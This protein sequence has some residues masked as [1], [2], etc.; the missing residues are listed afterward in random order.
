VYA[1]PVKCGVGDPDGK[2]RCTLIWVPSV[3]A[4]IRTLSESICITSPGA[5]VTNVPPSD[6]RAG[7]FVDTTISEHRFPVTPN[8]FLG[9]VEG[10][11][12]I[13]AVMVPP[14]PYW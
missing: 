5:S 11:A 8:G 4:I 6:E 9:Q 1:A 2:F 13:E 7:W 12:V 10:M 14:N 3:I